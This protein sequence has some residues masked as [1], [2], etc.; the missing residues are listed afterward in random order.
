MNGPYGKAWADFQRFIAAPA[1]AIC[2]EWA[3]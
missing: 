3:I 1:Y 2:G